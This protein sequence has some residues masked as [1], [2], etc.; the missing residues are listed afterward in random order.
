MGMKIEDL[1]M[2][3]NNRIRAVDHAS[4]EIPGGIFGLLG[5]NGA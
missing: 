2:T 4:L 1:T 3:F 5:E